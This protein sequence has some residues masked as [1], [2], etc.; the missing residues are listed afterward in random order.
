V[1]ADIPVYALGTV[2]TL[3]VL[4]QRQPAGG[5]RPREQG[6]PAAVLPGSHL[7]LGKGPLGDNFTGMVARFSRAANLVV[8]DTYLAD[9]VTTLPRVARLANAA[10]VAP[11]RATLEVVANGQSAQPKEPFLAADVAL[12][13]EAAHASFANGRLTLKGRGGSMLAD[14]SGLANIGLIQVVRS[15]STPGIV[16]RSVGNAP[17]LP[18]GMQLLQG[19][20]AIVDASGV[21]KTLDT[22]Y[23]GGVPPVD[24]QRAWLTRHWA[25]WGAPS[26]AIAVLVLLLLAAGIARKRARARTAAAAAARA[27]QENADGQ[28]G[29]DNTQSGS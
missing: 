13:N 26:I 9:P 14:L 27:A 16:Y 1:S 28:G 20:V 10:G 21:L 8:P 17:V 29:P 15:G 4:F 25:G 24:D 18:P 2:N 22:Q 6:Y 7:V 12:D 3:R 11:T 5:C 23:P 19:D